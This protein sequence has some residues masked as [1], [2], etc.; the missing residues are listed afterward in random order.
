VEG[1]VR[2]R[3][4][5]IACL[6]LYLFFRRWLNLVESGAATRSISVSFRSFELFS[7]IAYTLLP[8]PSDESIPAREEAFIAMMQ[9][10]E[11]EAG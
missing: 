11:G 9:S 6:A 2:G 5:R 4:I 1:L 10:Y 7:E 3:L 8:R